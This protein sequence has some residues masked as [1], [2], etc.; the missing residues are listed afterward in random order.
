MA[1]QK[2]SLDKE[3]PNLVD[4]LDQAILSGYH[5]NNKLVKI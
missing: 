2:L 5:K 3:A 4:P 1:F